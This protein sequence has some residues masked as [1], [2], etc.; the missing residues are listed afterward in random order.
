MSRER[1]YRTEAIV[2]KRTD[3]GEADKLL[4][5]YTPGL[6]KL[7]V[8]GK[9]VRRPTSRKSGHVELFTH[10]ELL[11]AKGRNLDIVTQ[12]QTI[13]PHL[14][15]REDLFRLSY[16]C[17]AAELVDRFAEEGVDNLPLYKLLLGVLDWLSHEPDLALTMRY[18][19]VQM[20][21][22]LGYSPQ[23]FQCVECR[24]VLQP[25]PQYFDPDAGGV[26]CPRCGEGRR[27]AI[28]LSLAALK[29]LRFLQ[30]REWELCRG[31]RLSPSTHAELEQTLYRYVVHLLERNLKSVEFLDLL[32]QPVGVSSEP[33]GVPA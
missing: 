17:Y 16:A 29:V 18:F 4:T 12:A 30:T 22:H 27:G 11:L 10:T 25:E 5:L 15:L 7:R 8:I 1:L 2:L 9:G 23:L 33:G 6:G 14:P 13:N 21:G 31:L 24:A 28:P 19:E 3:F 32:R 20:L 26:L